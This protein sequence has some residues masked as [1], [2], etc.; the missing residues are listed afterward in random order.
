MIIILILFSVAWGMPVTISV[1]GTFSDDYTLFT[2]GKYGKI[3]YRLNYYARLYFQ[4]Y[5]SSHLSDSIHYLPDPQYREY[6]IFYSYQNI[7]HRYNPHWKGYHKITVENTQ[8]TEI[9]VYNIKVTPYRHTYSFEEISGIVFACVAGIALIICVVCTLG[10]L[11][12]CWNNY[13][14]QNEMNYDGDRELVS[15]NDELDD[16]QQYADDSET[17]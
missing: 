1:N 9:T 13:R 11:V 15:Q 4:K 3:V 10:C 16:E 5:L 7:E 17:R 14:K 12:G 8:Q 6:D 2:E